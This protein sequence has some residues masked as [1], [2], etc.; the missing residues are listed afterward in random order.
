MLQSLIDTFKGDFLSPF[1]YVSWQTA[2]LRLVA[3]LLLGG[4]IG[5]ERER[6]GKSAGLRTNMMVS[7]AACMFTLISFD[8]MTVPPTEDQT[9]RLDPLRLIEAVTSGV[10]FLAAGLIF[11]QGGQA[12]GLTTGAGMWLSGAIG[13]ACGVGNLGLAVMATGLAVVMLW[14]LALIAERTMPPPRRRTDEEDDL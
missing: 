7:V 10:A 5:W 11:V 1:E 3:A 6:K 12:K 2:G 4:L 9:L 13:L 8:L 14:L